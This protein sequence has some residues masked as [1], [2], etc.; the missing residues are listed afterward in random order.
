LDA[1]VVKVMEVNEVPNSTPVPQVMVEGPPLE[2][3][4][5]SKSNFCPSNPAEKFSVVAPDPESVIRMTL[6][7]LV[8]RVMDEAHD[9]LTTIGT[10]PPFTVSVPAATRFIVP[11]GIPNTTVPSA[12]LYRA[13]S[14]VVPVFGWRSNP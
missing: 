9:G 13:K 8:V 2:G 7:P 14:L 10:T 3:C 11:V 1:V 6:Y 4:F 5:N 12:A